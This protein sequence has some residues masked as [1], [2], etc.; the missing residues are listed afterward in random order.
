[1]IEARFNKALEFTASA[2]DA[3]HQNPG[4]ED[5][6]QHWDY[7]FCCSI[8]LVVFR[9]ESLRFKRISLPSFRDS[10][11]DFTVCLVYLWSYYVHESH[12]ER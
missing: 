12:L 7:F 8:I 5:F 4:L 1:V 10:L 11:Q 9:Y 6:Q 2:S 3:R